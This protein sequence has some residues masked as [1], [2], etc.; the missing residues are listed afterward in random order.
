MTHTEKYLYVITFTLLA[1][2]TV[3]AFT[4]LSHDC[5]PTD[6]PVKAGLGTDAYFYYTVGIEDHFYLGGIEVPVEE[7]QE[8]IC[9]KPD[10]K[11]GWDTCTS[12]HF[13]NAERSIGL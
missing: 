10:G 9:V 11:A 13:M 7:Y 6:D 3:L 5:V 12:T 2:F 8:A 4:I 1:C